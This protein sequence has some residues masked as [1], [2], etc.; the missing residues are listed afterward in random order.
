MTR[1]TGDRLD[2]ALAHQLKTPTAALQAAAANLR[3]NLRGIFEDLAELAGT[4]AGGDAAAAFVARTMAE[5]AP[6]PITG[7]LPRDRLEVIARRLVAEGMAGDLQTTATALARG[8][9][10]TYLDDIVPLLKRGQP[11]M[12]EILETAARLRANLGAI[13]ASVGKVRRLASALQMLE[14]GG[15]DGTCD[16]PATLRASAELVS[17]TLPPGI[18]LRLTGEDAPPVAGRADLLEEVWTNLIVNAAQ[19]MGSQ[20]RIEAEVSADE[21]GWARVRV[22]D[23]GP[24]ISGEAITRIFDPFFTTRSAVGGTGLG[25]PLARRIVGLLGGTIRVES[26]P[27]RTC[28]TVLLPPAAP[29]AAATAGTTGA[30]DAAR[31]GGR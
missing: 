5:P 10:D 26:R 25:L 7:L 6:P 22:I 8:G 28:F 29:A 14:T 3:R 1:L 4:G 27:G 19:A 18:V 21:R 31:R 24:G 12:L 17:E 15:V 2:A 13:D 9:W 11:L 20:G 30:M 16:L 23:D